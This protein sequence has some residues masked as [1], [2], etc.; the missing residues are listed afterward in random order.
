MGNSGC[1]PWEKPA[2]T[3][4]RYSTYG[5]RWVCFCFHNAP[6][7]DMDY[8]IFL[9]CAQMSMHAIAHWGVRTQIRESTLEVD[10]RR[11]I[12]CYTGVSN[13][14]QRCAGPT[15]YQLSY[16][17]TCS[18]KFAASSAGAKCEAVLS[19]AAK[20]ISWLQNSLPLFDAADVRFAAT[21]F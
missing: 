12:P 18:C 5:V 11:K 7:S 20:L 4:S 6:N 19:Q 16:I 17:P 3:E 10:S 14:C 2:A 15:L 8:R 9:T 21:N 1:F 13:L